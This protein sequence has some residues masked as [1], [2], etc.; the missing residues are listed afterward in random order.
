MKAAGRWTPRERAARGGHGCRGSRWGEARPAGRRSTARM[1]AE[2]AIRQLLTVRAPL[3][4][5]LGGARSAHQA[6]NPA[7]EC[8]E[9]RAR[10]QWAMDTP[11]SGKA[12]RSSVP[13]PGREATEMDV[14]QL[15]PKPRTI[16]DTTVRRLTASNALDITGARRE[17]GFP[18][19]A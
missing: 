2:A 17:S 9:R 5:K 7:T 16:A 3:P 4:A 15:Y 12:M 1:R 11:G 13:P 18:R 14:K 6:A 10:D 19:A 8:D